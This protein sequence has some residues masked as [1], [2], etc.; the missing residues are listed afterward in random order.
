MEKNLRYLAFS[1]KRKKSHL[2]KKTSMSS[3]YWK[4]AGFP[5][6]NFSVLGEKLLSLIVSRSPKGGLA[7]IL[8][9]VLFKKARRKKMV[10][11][12]RLIGKKCP[13]VETRESSGGELERSDVG[14]AF[15][16][17]ERRG[18]SVKRKFISVGGTVEQNLT[19]A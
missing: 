9:S 13:V 10:S 12:E 8:G 7:T 4:K 18:S 19:F 11:F 6:A 1:S 3:G 14:W 15:D 16:G 17:R 5:R 2:K